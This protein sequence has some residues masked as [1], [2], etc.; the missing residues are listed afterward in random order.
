MSDVTK[1]TVNG[2]EYNSA[3]EMPPEVREEYLRALAAL[4]AAESQAAS[5]VVNKE[6]ASRTVRESIIYNGRE[7]RSRDE[8]P[9]EAR[10]LLSQMPAP[11]S[12]TKMTD[13]EIKTVRT[14]P[15]EVRIE[16]WTDE[17]PRE[18][19][20]TTA[21]LLVKILVVVVLILLFLLVWLAVWHKG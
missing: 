18:S 12:E 7:Y 4:R 16:E 8:L 10:E 14:F 21:W 11:S 13:V 1:I 17:E 2:R 20:P 5:G 19:Q 3:E 6:V 15:P 9:P